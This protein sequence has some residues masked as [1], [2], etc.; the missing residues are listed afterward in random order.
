VWGFT[1]CGK[2]QSKRVEFDNGR[3]SERWSAPSLRK[4]TK[5]TSKPQLART[6]YVGKDT[7]QPRLQY[8]NRSAAARSGLFEPISDEFRE[9]RRP[10]GGSR[11]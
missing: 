9:C 6:D 10:E 11:S 5:I 1:G 8:A 3:L 4:V 7:E 2:I